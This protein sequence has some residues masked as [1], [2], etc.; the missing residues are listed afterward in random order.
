[1]ENLLLE[2]SQLSIKISSSEIYGTRITG[3]SFLIDSQLGMRRSVSNGVLTIT[4]APQAGSSYGSQ[5]DMTGNDFGGAGQGGI[6]VLQAGQGTNSTI[7]FLTNQS[8]TSNIGVIRGEFDT[9]GLFTVTRQLTN[10]SVYTQMLV[11]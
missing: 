10:G 2:Q 11:I 8:P 1:V 4:G 7:R 9:F 6:L 5:I 3:S